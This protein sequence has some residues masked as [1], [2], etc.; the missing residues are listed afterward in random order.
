MNKELKIPV[1]PAIEMTLLVVA[2]GAFGMLFIAIGLIASDGYKEPHLRGMAIMVLGFG[3]ALAF[4]VACI[5]FGRKPT[6]SGITWT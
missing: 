1:N 5:A 3:C 6:N 2:M 4:L